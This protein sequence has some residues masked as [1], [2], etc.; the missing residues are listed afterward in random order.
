[1][2]CPSCNSSDMKRVSLIH[3]AGSY[4]SRG[5]IRGFLLGD[6]DGL[7]FGRYRGTNQSR[8][9]EMVR[10]PMK[11]PYATPA[12]LWLVGFFSL[13]AFVGRGKLSFAMGLASAA[14]ILLLPTLVVSVFVYNLFF[15]PKKYR[16]WD[17][18][19][20]CQRCGAFINTHGS[21]QSSL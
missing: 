12:I 2:I 20:M 1:M 10:P 8:L 3:A 4:Q 11:F 18:T 7:L 16:A 13:M 19:L 15:Y 6:S 5:R 21:L 17:G 9:S 14:Y